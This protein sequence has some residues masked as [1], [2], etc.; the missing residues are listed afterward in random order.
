MSDIGSALWRKSIADVTRR[1]ARTLGAILGILI[2]VFGLTAITMFQDTY[3]NALAYTNAEVHQSDITFDV[4]S[5]DS[6]LAS[7]LIAVPNVKAIEFQSSDLASWHIQQAPG[8]VPLLIAGLPDPAHSEMNR[9]ELLSGRYPGNG[10]IVLESGDRGLEPFALGDTVTVDTPLG[11]QHLRVVGIARTPGV[12][13]PANKGSALG[14]MGQ[15]ALLRI[16]GRSR[17]NVIQ[18]RVKDQAQVQLTQAQL[19]EVLKA[20][21]VTLVDSTL[22]TDTG[23]SALILSNLFNI[24]R[25]LSLVAILVSRV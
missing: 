19:S 13:D 9:F 11:S 7:T 4:Q 10:E 5:V 18:V 12:G 3:F 1:K 15:Q 24:M 17:P 14:Y 2:G 22:H 21:G 6:A 25:I 20:H 8:Q 16:M 23:D